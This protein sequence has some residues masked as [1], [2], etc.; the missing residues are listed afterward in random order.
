M[1]TDVSVELLEVTGEWV[2]ATRGE[3]INSPEGSV[4]SS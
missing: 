2:S 1:S 3:S 4:G